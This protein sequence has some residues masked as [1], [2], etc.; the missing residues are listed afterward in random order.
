[1]KNRGRNRGRK[2]KISWGTLRG[3][4]HGQETSFSTP[5]NTF[6]PQILGAC[7]ELAAQLEMSTW[8]RDGKVWCAPQ[9]P[10]LTF[11]TRYEPPRFA[12]F[13]T[14]SVKS[15]YLCIL[16]VCRFSR[17][18]PVASTLCI[19]NQPPSLNPNTNVLL[20]TSNG[21]C[22]NLLPSLLT[23]VPETGHV[24]FPLPCRPACCLGLRER[25]AP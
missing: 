23:N 18:F 5:R 1:M 2:Q 17:L 4:W 20:S 3:R 6:Y 11:S 7:S 14:E 15:W 25:Q 16:F 9:G 21:L 10:S 12:A 19:L 24:V 22:V 13:Q 8:H